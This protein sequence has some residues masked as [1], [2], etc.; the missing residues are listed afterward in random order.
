MPSTISVHREV[1]PAQG[2]KL[3]AADLAHATQQPAQVA[4]AA[5]Y[6]G[7]A[8]ISERMN[9]HVLHSRVPRDLEQGVEVGG[10]GMD[11][12]IAE[13]AEQ[14]QG[15][16]FGVRHG[17][18]QSGIL[19]QSAGADQLVDPSD[20]HLDDAARANVQVADF[21]VAHLAV[22]K[23]HVLSV[24]SDQRPGIVAPKAIEIRRAGQSDSVV[25][26]VRV[27]A[28]AVHDREH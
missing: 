19:G 9:E 5:G 20:V 7:V 21:A 8:A 25:G 14:V 28:P 6:R 13:Q 10:L 15:T 16:A 24:R 22:R 1:T 23:P 11:A 12:A 3:A 2:G 18:L 26:R 17:A 4:G 27:A